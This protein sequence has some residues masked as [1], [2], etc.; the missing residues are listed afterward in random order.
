MSNLTAE[1]VEKAYR[2]WVS[3]RSTVDVESAIKPF[4]SETILPFSTGGVGW[5]KTARIE[6]SL[7]AATVAKNL[8]LSRSAYARYEDSEIQGTITLATLA[9]AA[10]AMNCELVYAIRPRNRKQFSRII[11]DTVLPIAIQHSWVRSCNPKR[12]SEALVFIVKRLFGQSKFRR[13]QEWTQHP[14]KLGAQNSHLQESLYSNLSGKM[15]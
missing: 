5:L 14:K 9:K 3:K 15:V 13:Q 2:L 1:D 12:K 10:A 8:D 6:L 11:W 7:S 4:L